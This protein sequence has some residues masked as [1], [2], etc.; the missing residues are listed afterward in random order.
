[1]IFRF[2]YEKTA[3]NRAGKDIFKKLDVSYELKKLIQ[4]Q[5]LMSAY[6]S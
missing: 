3:D 6:R 5:V 2:I 1:M 4:H